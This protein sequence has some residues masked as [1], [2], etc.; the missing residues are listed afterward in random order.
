MLRQVILL[1]LLLPSCQFILV[2]RNRFIHL[3]L[4]RSKTVSYHNIHGEQR[5][6]VWHD[7]GC[8][9]S[10]VC[11]TTTTKPPEKG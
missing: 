7:F 8:F 10:V 6:H 1:G 3:S 2:L 4:P 9:N 5:Q 11:P